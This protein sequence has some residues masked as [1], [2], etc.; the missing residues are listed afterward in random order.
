MAKRPR[1]YKGE[2]ITVSFEMARCVHAAECA[3]GLPSIFNLKQRP[4]VNPDGADPE[5]ISNV[6]LQCPSGALK[7]ERTDG[8]PMEAIP[9][10]NT[11]HVATRGP[12]YF[13]GDI[14]ITSSQGDLVLRDTRVAL[15]RCGASENKPFCDDKHTDI[16]F[17][18]DATLGETQVKEKDKPAQDSALH[19]TLRPNGPILVQGLV[20]IQGKDGQT[21]VSQTRTALCRCGASENKP[22]CDGSHNKIGFQAE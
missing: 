2:K 11:I 17:D 16:Q 3:K 4:W 20:H 13:R 21:I 15:C 6:I 9:K 1:Q 5:V 22:F 18:H 19:I 14:K 10:K 7:F 12:L 8:G